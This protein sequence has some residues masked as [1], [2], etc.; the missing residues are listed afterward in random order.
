VIV[1]VGTHPDYKK[2]TVPQDLLMKEVWFS[3]ALQDG[4]FKEG[5]EK[6][7]RL[8]T[9]EPRAFD[10]FIYYLYHDGLVFQ[11]EDSSYEPVLT[12]CLATWVFGDKYNVRGLQN[13]VMLR[14]CHCLTLSADWR[15]EID[16]ELDIL[17]KYYSAAP[18]GSPLRKFIA[19]YIVDH[20]IVSARNFQYYETLAVHSGFMGDILAAKQVH[21]TKITCF[22]R[23]LR[24]IKYSHI[25]CLPG[26]PEKW[27][28][29]FCYPSV[30]A[31]HATPTIMCEDCKCYAADTV[32]MECECAG[33]VWPCKHKCH[34]HK[35]E[36]CLEKARSHEG[37]WDDETDW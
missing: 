16:L 4:R 15:H 29:R 13:A 8:P 28:G 3:G 19:E 30:R 17:G 35:C 2:Y 22:P 26:D 24:P 10:V 5:T 21:D 25:W 18:D 11:E 36:S 31:W 34:I 27:D 23:F 7:I 1:H 37:R 20:V 9:D 33:Q 12:L 6:I 14:A 32:C